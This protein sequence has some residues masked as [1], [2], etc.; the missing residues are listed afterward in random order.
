[1]K[2]IKLSNKTYNII[3]Y[4]V[5]AV[6]A[7]VLIYASYSLTDSYLNYKEDEAKYAEINNMFTK[8]SDNKKRVKRILLIILLHLPSGCGT[9]KLCFSTM[10]RQKA[11]LN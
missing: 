5:L 9:I 3:R 4:A 8:Q 7:V 11:T 1:M 10:M 2:K 6:A